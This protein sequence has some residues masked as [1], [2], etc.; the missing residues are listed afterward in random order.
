VV[1]VARY[2]DLLNSY[3]SLYNSGMKLIFICS[4]VRSASPEAGLPTRSTPDQL[5]L[6]CRARNTT[7]FASSAQFYVIYLMKVTY[8]HSYSSSYD[9]FRIGWL[10]GLCAV[11]PAALSSSL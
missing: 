4:S 6:L 5:P 7:D 10:V 9:T 8:Q 1:Y 2:T 11:R 3:I